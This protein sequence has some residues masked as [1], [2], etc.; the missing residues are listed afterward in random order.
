MQD[1]GT[2]PQFDANDL[3]LMVRRQ[4]LKQTLWVWFFS[5]VAIRMFHELQRFRALQDYTLVLTAAVLIYLPVWIY[6]RRGERVTFFENTLTELFKSIGIVLIVAL[7]IFPIIEIGDRYFQD[8]FFHAHY[9]GG[10]YNGL[11]IFA[12]F[13]LVLVAIP[14]EIFYRGY[15]Q[16]QLN[17]V[18][19]RPWR[20]LGASFGKSLIFTSMLF[21][22]SHSLIQLKWWHFSIFFPSLVF[23]WLR[24]K[25]GS[26]TAG[27]LF[28][29][30][31]NTFSFWAAHNY[32]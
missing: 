22:F 27:A 15:I 12:F 21:A 18:W 28:H 14:E 29:T 20:F 30:L 11:A 16:P 19:G 31:S 6:H 4:I 10:N 13:Q 9:F 7:A 5:M 17:R 25:T 26:V 1:N 32:R 8:I 3:E 2:P 24:E 23:G